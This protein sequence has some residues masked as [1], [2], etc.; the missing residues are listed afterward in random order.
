MKFDK[1]VE[2]NAKEKDIYSARYIEDSGGGKH[3]YML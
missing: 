3:G 2:K 1:M